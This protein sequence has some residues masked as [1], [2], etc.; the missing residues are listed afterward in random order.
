MTPPPRQRLR[1]LTGFEWVAR[2]NER[3]AEREAQQFAPARGRWIL[4]SYAEKKYEL[5]P[6]DLDSILPISREENHNGGINDIR[7]YNECD[8]QDLAELLRPTFPP[9]D[10]TES[11]GSPELSETNAFVYYGLY[12]V[13][14]RRIKPCRKEPN[15]GPDSFDKPE[16]Y[17]YN[18]TDVEALYDMIEAAAAAPG[19]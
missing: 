12:P 3:D 18:T 10:L 13:Q 15:T 14:L 1:D 16:L 11:D 17:F 5:A 19:P 2:Y 8:V 7:K 9:G 4:R 6:R